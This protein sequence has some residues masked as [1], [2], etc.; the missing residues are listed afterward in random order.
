MTIINNTHK[1]VFIHIPKNAG[2]TANMMLSNFTYWNDI[3]LGGTVYGEALAPLYLRRFGVSKHTKANL[4]RNL[5]GERVWE[6]YFKFAFVR[7]PYARSFSVYRFLKQWRNWEGSQEMEKFKSFEEFLS[8]DLF[9]NNPGPDSIF[10]PQHT[11]IED[12]NGNTLVDYTGKV[13]QIEEAFRTIANRVGI[14][15]DTGNVPIKNDSGAPDEFRSAYSE[16]AIAII[17]QRYQRDFRIFNYSPNFAT[18][19]QGGKTAA[20]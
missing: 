1:F 2:T 9:S 11:W 17:N 18:V 6:G 4:V 10:L 13:E 15:L 19:I 20:A 16:K 7:N 14:K 8:S 12:M 5:V 3:E